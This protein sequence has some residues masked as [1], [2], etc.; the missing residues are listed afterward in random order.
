MILT[1]NGGLLVEKVWSPLPVLD[2]KRTIVS[3][4]LTTLHVFAA[5]ATG[6][7]H[8]AH[9]GLGAL[10][11]TIVSDEHTDLRCFL[12]HDAEDGYDFGRAV[13]ARVL[14]HFCDAHA[15]ASFGATIAAAAYAGYASRLLEVIG[16]VDRDVLC[17]L[18]AS[19]AGVLNALLVYDE[20]GRAVCAAP[21]EAGEIGLVANL[22]SLLAFADEIALSR[23]DRT[24][25]VRL[26]LARHRITVRRL[27]HASLVLVTS[28][29]KDPAQATAKMRTTTFLLERLCQFLTA[30]KGT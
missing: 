27:A 5:K 15:G 3:A 2:S 6:G 28:R 29:S 21:V 16:A 4:L 22:R 12:F 11:V 10:A 23:E 13:G 9:I 7:L 18:R 26:E 19:C 25:A 14:G 24:A 30:I 17:E 1:A 8:L 20:D